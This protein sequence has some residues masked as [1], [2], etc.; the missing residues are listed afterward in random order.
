[1]QYE[2]TSPI[3]EIRQENVFVSDFYG[4]I[5]G[6]IL[7]LRYN[8]RRNLTKYII[9]SKGNVLSLSYLENTRF[10]IRSMITHFWNISSDIYTYDI[11]DN[12]D[13]QWLRSELNLY[14]NS[15]N[16]DCVDLVDVLLSSVSSCKGDFQLKN[17][18]PMMNL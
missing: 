18:I 2:V 9:D 4:K 16:P 5:E 10:G 8:F 17:A 1:M 11:S 3:I 12:K 14:L 7:R 15:D 13:V 6:S